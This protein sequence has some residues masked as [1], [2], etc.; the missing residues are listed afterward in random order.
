MIAEVEVAGGSTD[1]DMLSY[2][3][4]T[5]LE[6]VGRAGLGYSFDPN[7]QD[8]AGEYVKA[9][10]DVFPTL[11]SLVVPQQILTRLVKLG[12]AR[13]RRFVV[14]LPVCPDVLERLS[15]CSKR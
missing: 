4:R 7:L 6:V 8:T 15:M 12:T 5:A 10:K 1:L 14:L 9:M 2:S 3:T 13:M 11:A